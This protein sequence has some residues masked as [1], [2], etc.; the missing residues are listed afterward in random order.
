MR[1][2]DLLEAKIIVDVL[3]VLDNCILVLIIKGVRNIINHHQGLLVRLPSDLD[4][5]ND[6]ENIKRSPFSGA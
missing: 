5:K 2:D 1:H 6:I 3:E 4:F